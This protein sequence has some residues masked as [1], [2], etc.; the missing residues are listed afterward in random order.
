M[1]YPCTRFD[2][3]PMYPAAHPQ[4]FFVIF[5][6]L[7]SFVTPPWRVEAIYFFT[8]ALR[9]TRIWSAWRCACGA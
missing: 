6:I 5:V 9:A 3:L 4:R 1:C 7:V 8:A 2:L